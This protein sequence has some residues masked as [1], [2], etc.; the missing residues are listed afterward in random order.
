[1]IAIPVVALISSLAA[2]NDSSTIGTSILQDQVEVVVDSAF[3]VTGKSIYTEKVM[4]RTV[5]QLLGLIDAPGYGKLSSDIVMQFMPA[6]EMDSNLVSSSDIDSLLLY[7]YMSDGEYVGDS[8]VP[9]GLEVYRLTENLPSPI[10]SDFDPDGYY[11]TNPIASKIYNIS[12]ESLSLSGDT[13]FSGGVEISVKMPQDLAV[14]LFDAY[15]EHPEYYQ[16]PAAFIDNV[17]KGLY[18][19][20]SFGSGRL[21]RTNATI[22]SLYY[23]YYDEENDSTIYNNGNY[24]AVTP[25]VVNN[26]D[27]TYEMSADLQRRIN[28]GEQIIAAPVGTEVQLR[29]PAPEIIESYRSSNSTLSVLNTVTFEL[30]ASAIT[31]DYDF[32]VPTY[33]L[34]VLTKDREEFFAGNDLPDNVTSFYATYDS[35]SGT[36]TFDDMRSYVVDLLSKDSLTEDDYTFSLVP[37]SATFESNTSSSSYYYYYYYYGTTSQ[38]LSTL[39]PY[40]AAPV[41]GEVF[42]DKAKVKLTY[43]TQSDVE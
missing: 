24:F 37:V 8:I 11:D 9:M 14:E 17:F 10:Y 3:T 22:M 16:S 34:L 35:S 30:P 39:T 12:N 26:N 25:E 21:L 5:T 4:S 19:K 33:L 27:I 6:N 15:K 32:S 28:D 36:Y 1:M 18:I 42:L 31:N 23:H 43:S 38:T 2:C 29:F 40:M 20:N 7:M 41:M 13:V